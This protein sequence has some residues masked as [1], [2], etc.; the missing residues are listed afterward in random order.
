V[1][2]GVTALFSHEEDARMKLRGKLLGAALACCL[3]IVGSGAA[4]SA[5]PELTLEQLNERLTAVENARVSVVWDDGLRFVAKDEDA[6]FMIGGRVHSDWAW[7]G[8]DGDIEDMFGRTESGT[9]M[10]AARI[11]VGGTINDF[12]EFLA[13]YELAGGDADFK[14]VYVGFMGIPYIG[15]VR[16]GQQ[17]VPFNMSATTSGNE[18]MLMEGALVKVFAPGR[19]TG[20]KILNTACDEQVTWAFGAFQDTNS[21]GDG[22]GEDVILAGRVTALPIFDEENGRLVHVGAGYMHRDVKENVRFRAMPEMNMFPALIDTGNIPATD[23][24]AISLE[25]GMICGPLTLQ[26]EY[27]CAEVNADSGGMPKLD[28]FVVQAGYVLTGE[29]RGYHKESGKFGTVKPADEDC[30]GKGGKGAWEVVLRYSAV[31]LDDDMTNAG[32][33][34]DVTA[35]IN[36]YLNRNVRVM[37]NYVQADLE[38]VGNA[39]GVMMRFQINF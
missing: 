10:R 23:V 11:Y 34:E 17:F 28:G 31:N 25:A 9:E 27:I 15:T 18:T 24:D 21:Y 7:F 22:Q 6:T 33:L 37:L 38:H 3:V 20:I 12:V 39:E 14:S 2:S 26:S 4:F 19:E 30:V 35:G 5:E 13:Q 8:E 32:K 16:V 1:A 29:Q 36:W